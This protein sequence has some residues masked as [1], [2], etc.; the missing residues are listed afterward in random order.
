MSSQNSLIASSLQLL[1]QVFLQDS[2]SYWKCT[3]VMK[4]VFP[5]GIASGGVLT[6]VVV[7]NTNVSVRNKHIKLQIQTGVFVLHPDWIRAA[8]WKDGREKSGYLA[9][10][11]TFAR[12]HSERTQTLSVVTSCSWETCSGTIAPNPAR[13]NPVVC[14]YF[15]IMKFCRSVT[16]SRSLATRETRGNLDQAGGLPC[17]VWERDQIGCAANKRAIH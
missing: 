16:F 4:S 6:A 13:Y 2:T 15:S 11:G 7:E 3:D 10:V 5:K 14:K 8:F 9:L 1:R 12:R 17:T